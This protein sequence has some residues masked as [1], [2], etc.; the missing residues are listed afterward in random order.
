M[1]TLVR[2]EIKTVRTVF[3]RCLG[4]SPRG[5]F[6]PVTLIAGKD[7]IEFRGQSPDTAAAYRI[8]GKFPQAKFTIPFDVLKQCEGGK[9]EQATFT[10]DDQAVRIEWTVK[11]QPQSLEVDVEEERPG[12]PVAPQEL[13]ANDPRLLTALRDASVT[14]N[15]EST[16]FAFGCLQLQGAAG[17][18]AATDAGQLLIQDGF[19]FPWKDDVLI[20]ASKVFAC[21]QLPSDEPVHIGRTDDW[22]GI[23]VGPW[24]F[25]FRIVTD[26]KYPLVEEL[27]GQADLAPTTLHVTDED[28]E[29]LLAHIKRLPG[30]KTNHSAATL[31]L[32]GRVAL[33]AVDEDSDE[34]ATELTLQNS[35]RA[36][37][38]LRL[39]TNRN[40]LARSMQL[41]F[42]D[43]HFNGPESPALCC[44]DHRNY[45]W[46]LLTHDHAIPPSTAATRIE[47]PRC[48]P[49]KTTLPPAKKRPTRM[50]RN[51]QSNGSAKT[52][53]HAEN[54]TADSPSLIDR[55]EQLRDTLQ[56]SLTQCRGLIAQLKRQKKTS[57]LVQSTLASLRQLQNVNV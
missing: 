23:Q 12:F 42:R 21:R 34:P 27:V 14:T 33:R 39:N 35:T 47:S 38:A 5:P 52:N 18:I 29:F 36:G 31:D 49:A 54:S 4:S 20:T 51:P 57:K 32:N 10:Q 8:R 13:Q 28:A 1:I 45:V 16:R 55:A 6:P 40:Y 7:G 46:A 24:T 11:G 9:T 26:A 56:Q 25:Q 3:S 30:G 48:E 44:D 2:F 15:S 37:D 53:G 22:V 50:P 41:G 19:R 43:V 17:R